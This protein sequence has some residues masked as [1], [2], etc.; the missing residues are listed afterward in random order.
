M[1]KKIKLALGNGR[2]IIIA[3]DIA[4]ITLII[5]W[6]LFIGRLYEQFTAVRLLSSENRCNINDNRQSI[7]N[8]DGKLKAIE[9]KVDILL[10]IAEKKWR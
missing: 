9:T 7:Q 8:L 3:L 2:G 5:G 6:F 4:T 10:R 1:V